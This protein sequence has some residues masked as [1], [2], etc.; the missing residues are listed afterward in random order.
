[1]QQINKI[2]SELQI[3][4]KEAIKYN[5]PSTFSKSAKLQRQIHTKEKEVA[6]LE[7]AKARNGPW[8]V[9]KC[10]LILKV[11]TA[12]NQVWHY[13]CVASLGNCYAA[14]HIA[15]VLSAVGELPSN[16]YLAFLGTDIAWGDLLLHPWAGACSKLASRGGA[17]SAE[18][19]CNTAICC[20]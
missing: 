19:Y 17:T 9:D 3:L 7:D 15:N 5:T 1:L 20:K 18:I 11:T 4:K 12:A 8:T 13:S 2:I 14:S 16:L 10:I 6:M